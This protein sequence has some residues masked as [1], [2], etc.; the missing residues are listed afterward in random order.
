M[1]MTPRSPAGSA[2][3]A[4]QSIASSHRFGL[5]GEVVSSA[6][7]RRRTCACRSAA[8]RCRGGRARRR[9]SAISVVPP[10]VSSRSSGP[11]AVDEHHGRERAVAVGQRE[12]R[13]QLCTE[14]CRSSAPR[15]SSGR[16]TQPGQRGRG[17]VAA[18]PPPPAARRRIAAGASG[19][20]SSSGNR[21]HSSRAT[22]RQRWRTKSIAYGSASSTTSA[23]SYQK[24]IA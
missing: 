13:G 2:K 22:C 11:D 20:G 14:G 24:L 7:R 16:A 23:A 21:L 9:R 3:R 5:E 10:I 8:R 19:S 4:R 1:T 15:R 18:E 12:R 6:S 17:Q